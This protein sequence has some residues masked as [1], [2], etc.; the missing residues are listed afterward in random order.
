M[1]SALLALNSSATPSLHAQRIDPAHPEDSTPIAERVEITAEVTSL[2]AATTFH[3]TFRNPNNH[4]VDG[5]FSCPMEDGAEMTAFAFDVDGHLRDAVP[6]ERAR[7]RPGTNF[8][9]RDAAGAPSPTSAH[10]FRAR[11]DGIPAHSTREIQVTFQEN[12]AWSSDA[13]LYRLILDFPQHI[14]HFTLHLKVHTSAAATPDVHTNLDLTLPPWQDQQVMDVERDDF[15]AHG[16]LEVTVPKLERPKVVTGRYR[17]NE[18]FYAEIPVAPLLFNRPIPKVVGLLWDSSSSGSE[19]DHSKEF[20]LLD[21]WFAELKNVEVQ[22]IRFRDR[23]EETKTFSV[24]GGDWHAL[25]EELAATAYDGGTS[26]DGWTD[27]N[28]VD[29]WVLFSDGYFNYGV[30]EASPDLP[31][32]AIVHAINAAPHADTVWLR[33]AAAARDGEF[34][35][36]NRVD[37]SK[38][39]FV[40][41]TRSPHLLGAEFENGAISE[42]FP[43]IGSPISGEAIAVTGR[44]QRKNADLK[45]TIGHDRATAQTIEVPLISGDDPSTLAPRAWAHDKIISLSGDRAEHQ[46]EIR[47]LSQQFRIATPDTSLVVLESLDDYVRFDVNPPDDLRAEWDSRRQAAALDERK[48]HDQ[49][50]EDV[51]AKFRERQKWWERSFPQNVPSPTP[52]AAS[53]ASVLT[54]PNAPAPASRDGDDLLEPFEVSRGTP[55]ALASPHLK[56]PVFEAGAGNSTAHFIS[57]ADEASRDEPLQLRP[58]SPSNE[59]IDR[60]KKAEKEKR[61]QTYLAERESHQLEPAFYVTSADYFFEQSQSEVALQILSNLADLGVDDAGVLRILANRL[62]QANRPDLAAPVLERVLALRPEEPQSRRDLA[63]ADRALGKFQ[64]AANLL[65]EIVDHSWDA[66]FPE[67]ELIAL[68][69]LNGVIATC[70]QKLDTSK[71]DSRLLQNLPLDLRVILVWD[72]DETDM[73]LWVVDPNGQSARFDFPL[74]YQ[75]GKLSRDFASGY[76]PEEFD[77]RRAKPGKYAIKINYFGDRRPQALGPVTAR[78]KIFTG[79]GT[80]AQKEKVLVVHLQDK[81]EILDVGDI[82]IPPSGFGKTK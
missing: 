79:F 46:T 16:A 67:I 4:P 1:L 25:R 21:A 2:I 10:E 50:L 81:Q 13:G 76:G 26:L 40:L 71:M 58:M 48:N 59:Y 23:P 8:P 45:L 35:D 17:G 52:T 34:V 80:S 73:D 75:G 47:G 36:L 70:G 39:A 38:G 53:P 72:A 27:N 66:R 78:L 19:R 57:P 49:H 29:A 42:V 12:L 54:D 60:Y 56:S 3:L 11:I 63:L 77:L 28:S 51:V 7:A 22:L 68:T 62:L 32:H 24:K 55:A 5:T 9:R 74:T 61:F 41:Q 18:Y 43:I 31:F 65:W 82:I 64:S 6:V 30:K 37:A 15:P 69:D 20:A 14:P 44:M 33:A